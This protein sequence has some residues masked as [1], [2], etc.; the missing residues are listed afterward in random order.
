MS[1]Q[2]MASAAE[3]SIHSC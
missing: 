1:D 2:K 3:S